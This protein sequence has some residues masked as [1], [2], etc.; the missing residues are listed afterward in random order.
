MDVSKLLTSQITIKGNIVRLKKDSGL[1]KAVRFKIRS[2][3][4]EY[5]K[6]IGILPY[7]QLPLYSPFI[8]YKLLVRLY[9]TGS[10]YTVERVVKCSRLF[11][12]NGI[13]IKRLKSM[14][15]S[16]AMQSV[17]IKYLDS[18]AKIE[19]L[20][21]N[22]RRK[23]IITRACEPYFRGKIF[24]DMLR[25][26]PYSLL[27]R[28]TDSELTEIKIQ[29][30]RYPERLCFRSSFVRIFKKS[31]VNS[32]KKLND[33]YSIGNTHNPTY[34]IER[35]DFFL[36]QETT[37]NGK[38]SFVGSSPMWNT[39]MLYYFCQDNGINRPREYYS[40][41]GEYILVYIKCERTYSALRSTAF[42]RD[43]FKVFDNALFFFE[44]NNILKRSQILVNHVTYCSI[45]PKEI[46]LCRLISSCAKR[47]KIINTNSGVEDMIN[48]IA[49]DSEYKERLKNGIVVSSQM[50][51]MLYLNHSIESGVNSID[52][53]KPK[54]GR[55]RKSQDVNVVID[56]PCNGIKFYH[57]RQLVN[58]NLE[59]VDEIVVLS[60]QD[61]DTD[62]LVDILQRIPKDTQFVTI[63]GSTA[64]WCPGLP[65]TFNALV[66]G[67]N[68]RSKK[69]NVTLINMTA[70]PKKKRNN[71]DVYHNEEKFAEF[72]NDW[73]KKKETK[74]DSKMV[75][76]TNPGIKNMLFKAT[77]D[78]LFKYGSGS[79]LYIDSF[80]Y[81]VELGLYGIVKRANML[82]NTN[83][84]TLVSDQSV[85]ILPTLRRYKLL[86]SDYYTK[87]LFTIDTT[88]FRCVN[89]LFALVNE[90]PTVS[91]QIVILV[92][93]NTTTSQCIIRAEGLARTSFTIYC[94]KDIDID[95][96]VMNEYSTPTVAISEM[97]K[98]VIM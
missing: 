2:S 34:C 3:V 67:I 28:Y 33:I 47:V 83:T 54:R 70:K 41:L 58:V 91:Y 43:E 66:D 45:E 42:D 9:N 15:G 40:T 30:T 63:V 16:K 71:C 82:L 92:A 37:I 78:R 50:S 22:S 51:A 19:D 60:A 86:I 72:L 96:V 64:L 59:T 18:M 39:T 77:I 81:V 98:V 14:I 17:T 26:F 7:C 57:T 13:P 97:L 38:V 56:K 8:L 55:K 87:N 21:V 1:Q 31:E 80:V 29:C 23:K 93:D 35:W 88:K 20:P 32:A 44:E 76:L 62:S 4:S 85:A 74:W 6:E 53:Q 68:S 73:I 11:G 10:V 75:M 36:S 89:P 69:S 95:K 5:I 25:Y 90:I 52:R 24:F 61:L 46:Q 94:R 49:R 12:K 79:A 48:V 65:Y 84:W 27:R